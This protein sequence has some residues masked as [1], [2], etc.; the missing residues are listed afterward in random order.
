MN[1]PP[2]LSVIIPT[3]NSAK[4]LPFCLKSVR[5]QEYPQDRVEI[6]IVDGYSIDNTV[7]IAEKFGCITIFSSNKPL[8]ARYEGL[9]YSSGDAIILLDADHI[10]RRRNLFVQISTMLEQY[11]MLHL[12]ESSYNPST[13]IQ[14]LIDADKRSMQKISQNFNLMESVL[15]A[16]AYKREVLEKAYQRIPCDALK[17]VH[18]HEE[19]V[20]HYEV[21][22]LTKK[23][24]T[25]P[26]A[27]WHIDE[28]SFINYCKKMMYYGRQDHI[29]K[30]LFKQYIAAIRLKERFRFRELPDLISS[31]R[32]GFKVL[33]LL[34]I[35]F[36]F[37][38]LGKFSRS[39][40]KKSTKEGKI[41]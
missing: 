33:I 27:L 17:L 35:K 18:N 16:R 34:M 28:A 3:K 8:G 2:K 31:P 14:K 10:I 37:F 25:I 7:H 26:N 38:N 5:F 15:Y 11:D 30:K 23:H 4:T 40:C 19:I 36:I 9:I 41:L 1:N 20:L 13:F 32:E 12:Q 6:I 24:A 21:C 39:A 22:K 29:E